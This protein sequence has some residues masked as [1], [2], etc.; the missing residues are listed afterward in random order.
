[1]FSYRLCE[2]LVVF[3]PHAAIFCDVALKRVYGLQRSAAQ[4]GRSCLLEVTLPYIFG[5][6]SCKIFP[7]GSVKKNAG[8][9]RNACLS[10]GQSECILQSLPALFAM[11]CLD[12]LGIWLRTPACRCN[13]SQEREKK[14]ANRSHSFQCD[15]NVCRRKDGGEKK[16]VV[17]NK[18]RQKSWTA[19]DN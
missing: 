4:L 11:F 14:S 15:P 10:G 19:R 12:D 18:G 7:R 6:L 17:V 5:S 1:M 16:G 9:I 2:S 8:K 13:H 3:W